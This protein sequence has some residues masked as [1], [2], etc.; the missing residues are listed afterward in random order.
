MYWLWKSICYVQ[1]E[2]DQVTAK[3]ISILGRHVLNHFCIRRVGARG[4][5]ANTTRCLPSNSRGTCNQ[6]GRELPKY[7]TL[8]GDTTWFTVCFQKT[9]YFLVFHWNIQIKTS[10]H[11]IVDS[12]HQ[13]KQGLEGKKPTRREFIA[14]QEFVWQTKLARRIARKDSYCFP[15]TIF[16]FSLISLVILQNPSK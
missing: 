11:E 3:F 10:K 1:N 7:G 8:F 6:C 12:I 15:T 2:L 14:C 4:I 16:Y 9:L 5:C 13:N